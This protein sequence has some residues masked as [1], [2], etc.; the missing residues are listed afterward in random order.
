[1]QPA[2]QRMASCQARVLKTAAP[3]SWITEQGCSK[4][5]LA[6]CAKEGPVVRAGAERHD[7]MRINDRNT[8]TF[9]QHFPQPHLD[10]SA[11]TD[12][13][14]LVRKAQAPLLPQMANPKAFAM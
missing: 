13:G 10:S 12:R 3:Y 6:Q 8:V 7:G 11:Q 4:G 2:N 5:T 1:M 14:E 9:E